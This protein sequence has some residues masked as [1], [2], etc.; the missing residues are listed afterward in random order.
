MQDAPIV[1]WIRNKYLSII[2]DLDERGRRRWAAAEVRSLGWGGIAAVARATG[3]S[4]RTIRNGLR[5][6]DDP[7]ALPSDRQRMQGRRTSFTRGN[8]T[9]FDQGAGISHRT[10]CP[11]GPNVSLAVDLQK[12]SDPGGGI[13]LPGLRG[14]LYESGR[15]VEGTRL[16]PAVEPQDA[17][18]KTASGSQR[19]VRTYCPTG[20]GPAALWRTG[21]LGRREEE[22]NAGE[23]EK[24]RKNVP[25]QR[26][27][28]RGEDA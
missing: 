15:T 2:A 26:F 7:D 27:S 21:D 25:P 5:E 24:P 3:I 28:C 16:Q 11:R 22:G 13:E 19:P 4:D 9:G 18:G 10:S 1:E 23:T 8:P 20:E 12:Y 6:L 14:Q 17:G